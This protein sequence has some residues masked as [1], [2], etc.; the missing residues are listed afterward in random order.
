[1]NKRLEAWRGNVASRM[2]R[3][4]RGRETLLADVGAVVLIVFLTVFSARSV[5]F[6]ET[7]Y[8]GLD[9]ATQFYPWY[10][11]L[12]ETLRA[13]EIPGWNPRQFAGAPFA[14]DPLSGWTYLPAMVLF[15]LLPTVSAAAKSYAFF[16]LLMAGL[17]AFALAR[18]LKMGTSGALVAAVAYE[19][20]NYIFVRNT[21]CFAFSSVMVWL[22]VS[23][24]GAEMAIRSRRFLDR[25]L[26][27]A[28]SG[29][30]MSQIFASWLGQ[31]AYYALLVLG[32]YVAYRAFLFPPE[33]AEGVPRRI[34]G[35]V[36]VGVLV[37][38]FGFGFAAAGLVPRL[39]YNGLSTL[40]G[41]YGYDVLPTGGLGGEG[42]RRLIL[43]PS[44]FY[45]GAGVVSLA[46]C[47]PL[48]ALRRGSVR[49][50]VP[51]FAGLSIVAFT[52]S[53]RGTTLIHTALYELPM[54]EGLLPYRSQRFMVVFFLGA[55]MLAG[56]A[57]SHLGE[58]GRKGAVISLPILAALFVATRSDLRY[59]PGPSEEVESPVDAT[60][61]TDSAPRLLDLGV[62]M[63]PGAFLALLAATALATAY[64]LFP[65]RWAV[66]RGS[67]AV[68]LALAVFVDL[69]G[70]GMAALDDRSEEA[71]VREIVERDLEEYYSPTN[72][73][74]FLQSEENPPFRYV[75]HAPEFGA[76]GELRPLN[77]NFSDITVRRM[78]ASNRATV[79]GGNL[80]NVQGYNAVHLARFDEYLEKMNG[81]E[82]NYHDAEIFSRGT[83]SPLLD[84]LDVRYVVLPATVAPKNPPNRYYFDPEISESV[85]LG[86]GVNIFEN[87]G[88]AG[89]AWIVHSAREVGPDPEREIFSDSRSAG[90]EILD[91]LDAGD[92]DPRETA[93]LESPPPNLETPEAP[94]TASVTEYEANRMEVETSTD[95]AGL[96]VMSEVYYPGWNAYVDGERVEVERA[97][98]LFR[99]VPVPAGEHTV[100]L[101]YESRS[102][103]AGILISFLT[104]LALAGLSAVRLAIRRSP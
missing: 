1:M 73:T 95:A 90:Q 50:G 104:T 84:L 66:P 28:L 88:A 87:E 54:L 55:A 18:T 48:L 61:W 103:R 70:A 12:G 69:N 33:S 85:Y 82:Q 19:F 11:L 71:G 53:G 89:R 52:L 56:A 64:A 99:A 27:C 13:G 45:V 40:A 3:A 21:C 5:F 36:F 67:F 35:G 92:V 65:R 39:E 24:L 25:V 47:A 57:I 91:L 97:N 77:I 7:M 96:L 20:G 62:Q 76:S 4:T 2:R 81:R 101:R 8:V 93:L 31:G 51:F 80:Y 63:A 43:P 75:S 23:I 86:D 49:Y 46:L 58:R 30:A 15:T 38:V 16:H 83:Y 72:A 17:A 98:F 22:P 6:G 60:A 102:L 41:G 44:D 68:L 78:E 59:T 79:H 9:A 26:W 37:L 32:A 10:S 94:S 29:F 42:W 14:A 100:E 34:F 74:R